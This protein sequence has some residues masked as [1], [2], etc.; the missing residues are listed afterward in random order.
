MPDPRGMQGRHW[1]RIPVMRRTI[2]IFG[3]HAA[4]RSIGPMISR[5]IGFES[6][7]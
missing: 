2:Y 6:G 4:A 7:P 3:S 1:R 5:I